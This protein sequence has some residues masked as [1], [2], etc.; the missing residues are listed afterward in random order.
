[1]YDFL[2]YST[3]NYLF[4]CIIR[5]S[6]GYWWNKLTSA[7]EVY[8]SS[9]FSSY[10]ILCTEFGSTGIYYYLVPS[11]LPGS[12]H[13]YNIISK[14]QSGTGTGTSSADDEDANGPV[15]TLHWDG[16]S[17]VAINSRPTLAQ[18]LAGGD[19]DGYTLEQTLK[20]CLAALAGKISGAGTT[21]IVIRAADDSK[22]RIT[23]T[24]TSRGN[25]TVVT[26]DATG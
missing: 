4:V 13:P 25:R 11:S 26:L 16:T 12:N 9:N 2:S 19:I 23:A 6:D 14:V 24:V 22:D 18:I 5:P 10:V 3:G 15:G 20:I 8:N 17:I 7:F 1:M 21:S